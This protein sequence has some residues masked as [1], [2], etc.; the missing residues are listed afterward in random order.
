MKLIKPCSI[1]LTALVLTFTAVGCKTRSTGVTPL[2]GTGSGTKTQPA[3]VGL[4]KALPQDGVNPSSADA[5]IDSNAIQHPDVRRDWQRDREIFKAY[6]VHFDY[7]SSVIKSEEKTKL[8]A[9]A[10]Y[11]KGH[12]L[13]AL[14]IEGHCDARGTEE[15]NRSL[16]ERRALALRE[17]LIALGVEASRIDTVSFGE[18]RPADAGIDDAAY[19]KNRRGEFLLEKHQTLAGLSGPINNDAIK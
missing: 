1:I 18:D 16:G 5:V 13:D 12:P 19:R 8:T 4:G 10:E 15:Y 11:I 7:D 6:T 9:V 2:S 17:E 14:E 3:E